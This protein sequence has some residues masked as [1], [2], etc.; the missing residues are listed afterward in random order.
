MAV[1]PQMAQAPAASDGE[2]ALVHTPDYI[3]AIMHGTLAAAAAQ[4]YF[5][6]HILS[7]QLY[8]N[9]P[10]LFV[11]ET[12]IFFLSNRLELLGLA[13]YDSE[14]FWWAGRF[15]AAF[16]FF[17]YASYIIDE[18]FF[19]G[20]SWNYAMLSHS[21]ASPVNSVLGMIAYGVPAFWYVF[22]GKFHRRG[23]N[24]VTSYEYTGDEDGDEDQLDEAGE[25]P[26]D[27]KHY[28]RRHTP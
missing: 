26:D 16:V 5:P 10:D 14:R 17:A 13:F 27:R 28:E 23:N 11:Y 6:L 1:I 21:A 2:L 12:V 22:T 20:H 25:E 19:S 9:K 4:F 7:L 8:Q 18:W 15:V 24:D 3:A